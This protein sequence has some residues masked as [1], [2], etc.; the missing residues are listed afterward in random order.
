[1]DDVEQRRVDLADVV[2]Q[3][4]SL[5]RS[6]FSLVESDRFGEDHR[7]RCDASDVSAGGGVIGVD[8]IQERFESRGRKALRGGSALPDAAAQG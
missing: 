3:G 1:M 2:E 5:R 7:I 4:D 8:G 6:L